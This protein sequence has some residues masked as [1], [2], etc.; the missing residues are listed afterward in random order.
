M[1]MK[2]VRAF[3]Y[4][5]VLFGSDSPWSSQRDSINWL[6]EQPLEPDELEAILGGNGKKLL[7]I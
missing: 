2:L 5:R 4:R 3:G 6:R 7:G 1:F